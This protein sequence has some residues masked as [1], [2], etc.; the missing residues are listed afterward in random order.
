[1]A[2]ENKYVNATKQRFETVR[3][4]TW[5]LT[6]A[7]LISLA[8]YI[9]VNVSTRQSINWV[10][11]ILLCTMQI[12]V[13]SL[14]FPDGDI[15]GQKDT[16]FISN[17]GAYNKK[18]NEINEKKEIANLRKYCNFEFEERKQRYIQ[19]QCGLI[20]ITIEELELLKQHDE[21]YILELQSFETKEIV[22]GEE[23]SRLIFFSKH[24]RKILYDLIFKP[25]PVEKN[26]P[27]TIMS[28][29]ENN[30]NK[31]IRDGSISYKIHSYIRKI[32]TAVVVGG[33]FAYIGYTLRDGFGFAQVVQICMYIT[34]LFTTAVMAFSSG[35]TC[36]KVHKSHFYLDLA[37]FIDGFNEWN[38]KQPKGNE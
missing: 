28:A 6:L 24:K 27:E 36:S 14:Y 34:T 19:N 13:H 37:N 15:F 31:A 5:T 32:L 7:I 22:K 4:R 20:G 25:L 1:M 35:E 30:G 18:A 16:A 2:E 8:L 38:S 10:D 21:K 9:V 11:F 26:Y 33:I 17:K 23:K 3:L 12:V 29:V